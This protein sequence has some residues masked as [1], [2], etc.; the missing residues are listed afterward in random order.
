MTDDE[1]RRELVQLLV[2]YSYLREPGRKFTLASGRLSDYYLECSLTTTRAAAMPLIG[3]L[4]HARVPPEAVAV[5]G[6]TMGADP[7]AAAV[8][9]HSA[10][11]SHPLSWFSVRKTP[12]EHGTRRWLEGSAAP[13]DG[14]VVVED[15]ITSGGSLLDAIAR[16]GEEGLRVLGAVVLVDREE[17]EGRA[18][19]DDALRR[20]DARFWALFTRTEIEQ[21]WRATPAAGRQQQP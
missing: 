3:A 19:V 1:R 17:Q 8:S 13:G 15:V 12:K 4:I 2:R 14:V 18:R 10:G 21:A 5:G 16:C 7:I 11:T 9:F 6:P 20:L